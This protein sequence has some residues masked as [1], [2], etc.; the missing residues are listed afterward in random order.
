[1]GITLFVLEELKDKGVIARPGLKVLDIGSSNLYQASAASV[2][3]YVRSFG[4]SNDQDLEG[5]A[6]RIAKGSAYD[7]VKG[8]LNESF[9]GELLE[10]CGIDYLSF[11]IARG[12]KTRIFDLNRE[13]LPRKCIGAFDVVLN[14][15][16][17]EHVLNQY[18]CFKVIHE[19]TRSGG[20]MIHQL[21]V[22]GATDHGYFVY[23]G[24][25]LFDLAKFNDYDIIEA[26]YEGPHNADDL[27]RS[28]SAYASY[29]PALAR[30]QPSS[31]GAIPNF[32]LT[33][34]FL[35]NGWRP[36]RASLDTTTSVGEIPVRVLGAY[37]ASLL[38]KLKVRVR[39]SKL[40][41]QNPKLLRLL[42]WVAHFLRKR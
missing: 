15:G 28:V 20:Y 12:Y 26:R 36:F 41:E 19:A 9:V 22:A 31:S 13:A 39:R 34:I 3:H 18:N 35:K 10:R 27:Y 33:V 21:P 2:I 8:G 11:D 32:S 5:F 29:F 1:M 40:V 42:Q 7:A 30:L 14:A 24:R 4:G 37:P 23:T 25:M 16:T 6:R 17:T 38:T